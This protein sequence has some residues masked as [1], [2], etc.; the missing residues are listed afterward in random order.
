VR[1]GFYY[2]HAQDWSN[3]GAL[4]GERWDPSQAADF[5]HYLDT[6]SIPQIRELL[7]QYGPEVPAVLW[8]DT[9]AEMTPERCARV[10]AAVQS[11]RPGILQNDRLGPGFPGHFDTPEQRI[12]TRRPERPWE[13]CMT[14]NDSWGYSAADTNWKSPAL[15]LSQL[16]EV[17]SQGGN[18]LLNIGPKADGSVPGPTLEVLRIMGEWMRTNSQAIR[19][20]SAGPFPYRLDWGHATR[21][22]DTVYLL[23]DRWPESGLITVPLDSPPAAA[24]LLADPGKSLRCIKGQG[25]FELELPVNA[26]DP[27]VSVVALRYEAEPKLGNMPP[28]PRPPVIPQPADGSMSLR[29]QDCEIVGEHVALM[30]G[31]DPQLGCWTSLDSFPLWRVNLHRGAR[32]LVEI[33]YAVPMHRQ[34]TLAH[35]HFGD[36]HLPFV[37][38]GTGGWGEFR[39][40]R[41]GELRLEP[42]TEMPVKVVPVNIPV[43][44]V[45]NMRAVHLTPLD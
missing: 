2:S 1:I 3:G 4:Y 24:H 19:G 16:C 12:P 20:A 35:L 25:E 23:I 7:T 42:T 45:M 13:T 33:E 38:A 31:N 40:V 43:G 21:N 22:G 28:R 26:T 44:A 32:Y 9:P 39:R 5:D 14:T 37:S 29:A 41:V 15:L 10:D 17:V 18:Y 11:L 36:Q 34:G 8:W 6:V 27:H 30:L